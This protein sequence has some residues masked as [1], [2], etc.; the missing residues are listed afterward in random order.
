M[1]AA[2]AEAGEKPAP[3][4]SGS[5]W[6]VLDSSAFGKIGTRSDAMSFHPAIQPDRMGSSPAFAAIALQP[7]KEESMRS[8]LVYSAGLQVPN[9]FLLATITIRA[10]RALHIDSTRT[11]DTANQVL[12][13][14]ATGRYVDAEMPEV[15]PLPAIEALLVTPAA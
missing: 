3:V 12:A 1:R 10:V 8:H 15:A 11:E 9:R 14:I 2:Y 4:F 13:E 7:G 6:P 5:I